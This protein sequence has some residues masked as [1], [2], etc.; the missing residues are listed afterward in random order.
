M[1]DITR[2]YL[3]KRVDLPR[4]DGRLTRHD[5]I[6]DEEFDQLVAE[7]ASKNESK[8]DELAR[9][10]GY[11]IAVPPPTSVPEWLELHRAK[12]LRALLTDRCSFH[13]YVGSEISDPE[14]WGCCG[15][16]GRLPKDGVTIHRNASTGY[17]TAMF[18]AD[19]LELEAGR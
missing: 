5:E 15:N 18:P 19:W 1:T 8:F 14:K 13:D 2:D 9:A 3:R 16:R 12:V 6:T 11:D 17:E 10:Q 7:W 4:P